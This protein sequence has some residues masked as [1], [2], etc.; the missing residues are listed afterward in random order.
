MPYCTKCGTLLNSGGSFCKKCGTKIQGSNFVNSS[1]QENSNPI[2]YTSP[3]NNIPAF[4][5]PVNNT[6]AF[7]PPVNNTPVFT[8]P[9]NNT[10]V[11]TP[12]VR[13]FN[14]PVCY[15][16]KD[17]PAAAQCAR[18]GKYICR[19]CAE[20][21]TV[22]IGEYANQ[23]LCYDCCQAIVRENV[24]TLQNQKSKIT[25]TFVLTIIG[26]VFGFSIGIQG[27]FGLALI[28]ALWCG[29]IWVVL[30]SAFGGFSATGFSFAGLIG[31]LIA[32]LFIGPIKTIIKIVQCI[33]Y[34][35]RTA[36]FIEE[37]TAALHQM[38][39]YMEYTQ[40]MSRNRGVDLETLLGQGS[41]LYNNTYAQ[42]VNT[43]GEAAADAMLRQCTTT[44]AE[45]G[46]IIRSFAA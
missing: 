13:S 40:V 30:K 41:E 22:G 32:G 24:S 33:K 7:T 31:G 21:Y 10:P 1:T 6:P 18:C 20:A 11:F 27:G 14:G 19:D 44:I 34:M 39:D 8:P 26:M 28:A 38:K 37:D 23:C 45:N 15:H 42:L 9:V 4:T 3:V 12:P 5:P 46:E 35:K 36:T 16:H 17:E 43:K 25:T 2:T 29:S